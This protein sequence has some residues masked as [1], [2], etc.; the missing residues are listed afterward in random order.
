MA[1]EIAVENGR[2]ANFERFVTLTLILDRVITHTVVHHSSTYTYTPNFIKIE[3]TFC[4]WT[5]RRTHV[6][7]QL[8]T[9]LINMDRDR[10]LDA[11]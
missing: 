7:G 2:I 11:R 5:D 1:E 6:R 10:E 4:G 8:T 3:E 9:L